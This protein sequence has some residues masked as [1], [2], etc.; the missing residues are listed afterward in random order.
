MPFVDNEGMPNTKDLYEAV[1]KCTS[2]DMKKLIV[3]AVTLALFL[4]IS[5]F[6]GPE[7]SSKEVV[8]PPP[9]APVSFFRGNEFDIGA[10]ATYVTGTNGGGS[11]TRSRQ[12]NPEC[13]EE[14]VIE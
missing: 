1:Y 12:A 4:P 5:A 13:E 2:T 11:V 8:A 6:G 9:P 14:H 3:L 7:V 10:F